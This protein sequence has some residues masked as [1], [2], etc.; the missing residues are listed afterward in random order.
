MRKR[1]RT[2]ESLNTWSMIPQAR[3]RVVAAVSW[4]G[5]LLGRVACPSFRSGLYPGR[6]WCSMGDLPWVCLR[7][8]LHSGWNEE[9]LVQQTCK[10]AVQLL[11][12]CLFP[13]WSACVGSPERGVWCLPSDV[14]PSLVS[15]HS[16]K[17]HQ[18]C[19]TITSPLQIYHAN[20]SRSCHPV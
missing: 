12:R 1:G 13:V 3:A 6:V 7:T 14:G 2:L 19:Q 20:P 4:L 18:C 5:G 8:R 16:R 15:R 9:S 10:Q 11:R 17:S